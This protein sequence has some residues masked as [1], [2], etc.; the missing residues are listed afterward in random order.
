MRT[1]PKILISAFSIVFL[2]FLFLIVHFSVLVQEDEDTFMFSF[3]SSLNLLI[4]K[5]SDFFEVYK[6]VIGNPSIDE[7]EENLFGSGISSDEVIEKISTEDSIKSNTDGKR[8][9]RAMVSEIDKEVSAVRVRNFTTKQQ[10]EEDFLYFSTMCESVDVFESEN[11]TFIKNTL[12]LYNEIEV[13]DILEGECLV[14]NCSVVGGSC[15]LIK[16]P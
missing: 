13:G 3:K 16:L 2:I 7:D 14:E 10:I 6:N 12:D 8:Y 1:L 11:Y 5:P 15:I 9:I 4:T